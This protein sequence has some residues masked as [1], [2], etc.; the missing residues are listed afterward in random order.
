[1][2]SSDILMSCRWCSEASAG[3]EAMVVVIRRLLG[4][5]GRRF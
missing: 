1:M 5:S 2:R 3:K 4:A